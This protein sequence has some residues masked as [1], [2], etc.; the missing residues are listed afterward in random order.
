MPSYRE[1]LEMELSKNPLLGFAPHHGVPSPYGSSSAAL[2]AMSMASSPLERARLM[3]MF[4]LH[5]LPASGP[6]SSSPFIH[7]SPLSSAGYGMDPLKSLWASSAAGS[8][9]LPPLPGMPGLHPHHL[10][11][12]KSLHEFPSRMMMPDFLER[13]HILARYNILNSHGGGAP[14]TEKLKDATTTFSSSAGPSSS[15][16]SSS[17]GQHPSSSS[18][19]DKHLGLPPPLPPPPPVGGLLPPIPG[20]PPP[21]GLLPP[22]PGLLPPLIPPPPPHSLDFLDQDLLLLH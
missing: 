12:F 4:G 1:A 6:A 16:A 15:S 14:L 7:P 10:D 5:G 9:F 13:E 20:V 19:M 3:G 2:A 8:P 21:S 18:V 17:S 11:P 22:P